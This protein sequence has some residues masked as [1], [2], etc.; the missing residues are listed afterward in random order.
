M[1]I[2]AILKEAVEKGA[3]DVHLTV[4]EP[5]VFRIDGV[6]QKTSAA[7]FTKESLVTT[8]K[9]SMH[10]RAWEAFEADWEAD[11]S[12]AV[13]DVARFRVNVYRQNRGVSAAYRVIPSKVPSLAD[14][15]LPDVFKNICN[16]SNGLVLVTGPTGSG[17]S[18][19]LAAMIDYLNRDSE[20]KE[21]IL[22]IE[23]PIE[24]TYQNH[25]CL[26]DQRELG[27]DTKSFHNALRSALREDP[28]IILIGEMR[29]QESIRLALSAAETGHLVFAT[30]HTNSAPKTI[31]RIVDSFDGAEAKMIRAM[32]A[33]SLRAIIS[34]TLLVRPGGGRVAAH[35]ILIANAAA[36]NLIREQKV[37]QLFSV[38]QTGKAEGMHTMEQHIEELVA[39]KMAVAPQKRRS[40]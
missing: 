32:L 12:H 26:I 18:T 17:K 29:D 37:A 23:D 5:P 33:E 22:T 21:H 10:E 13:P 28:D 40:S 20:R 39:A 25:Q 30:L 16:Y 35:E 1:D 24:F 4:G 7:A 6:L 8:I 34:Q 11:F 19:T 38:M 3:S 2:N 14:L 27:R 15:N 9:A 36:R 31:D